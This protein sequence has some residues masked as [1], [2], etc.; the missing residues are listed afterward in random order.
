MRGFGELTL[1]LH[2]FQKPHAGGKG[3]KKKMGEFLQADNSTWT[4][5][6]FNETT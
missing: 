6:G 5:S 3:K 2:I 4:F 1:F